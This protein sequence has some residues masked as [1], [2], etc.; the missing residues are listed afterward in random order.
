MLSIGIDLGGTKAIGGL[1]DAVGTIV[2]TEERETDIAK[3]KD[4]V[5]GVIADIAASLLNGS[6]ASVI[7]I[8]SAGRVNCDNGTVYFA[9]PNLPDWTGVNVK[10]FMESK[11]GLP[12]VV[13]NDV[14]VAGIGEMWLGAGRSYSS[15]VCLTLGTGLAAAVFVNGELIRGA[16]W[17]TGEIGHMILYPH[18]KPCNCGQCGCFEQYCSGT[19]LCRSYNDRTGS[20]RLVSG[21]Q[22]FDRLHAGDPVAAQVLDKFVGDLAIGLTSLCNVYDPEAFIIGGGLIE[23]SGLWWDALRENI[24]RYA[25]RAVNE[26]VLLKAA[27]QNRAGLLGAAKLGMDYLALK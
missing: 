6:A 7:G 23:T 16:H 21:K 4:H 11:F 17:S 27:F 15:S 20:D 2:R 5:L 1:V 12:S 24:R 10:Q 18:G 13:D 25:N 8:G 14:N 22:F 26:P 3:G 19:A 9:T